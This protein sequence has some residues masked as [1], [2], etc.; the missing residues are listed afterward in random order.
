MPGAGSGLPPKPGAGSGPPTPD[1]MKS[2][3]KERMKADLTVLGKL[4]YDT[5]EGALYCHDL[6]A[7]SD[8]I[9]NTPGPLQ[10]P[11]KDLVLKLVSEALTKKAL[12]KVEDS[13]AKMLLDEIYIADDKLHIRLKAGG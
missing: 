4:R 12:Y 5:A 2:V 10:G 11:I 8:S 3:L 6:V 13:T 9:E 1:K 7:Q